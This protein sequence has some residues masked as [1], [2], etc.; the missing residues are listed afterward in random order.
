VVVEMAERLPD[1][2]SEQIDRS[3]LPART[4]RVRLLHRSR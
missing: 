2:T 3:W 4:A 1:G